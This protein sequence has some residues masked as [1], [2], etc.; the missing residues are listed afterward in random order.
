MASGKGFRGGFNPFRDAHGRFSTPSG[1]GKTPAAHMNN[2]IRTAAGRGGS[3]GGGDGGSSGSNDPVTIAKRGAPGAGETW[4]HDGDPLE[5]RHVVPGTNPLPKMS[6][7]TLDSADTAFL[8]HDG[9]DF[10]T[11]G[12]DHAMNNVPDKAHGL[13]MAISARL[14]ESLRER[15]GEIGP[16][17]AA[18]A[19]KI[20]A[21]NGFTAPA[22]TNTAKAMN[23]LLATRFATE[24]ND[25]VYQ[26]RLQAAALALKSSNSDHWQAAVDLL[27]P[28]AAGVGFDLTLKSIFQDATGKDAYGPDNPN[29]E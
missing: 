14:G 27:D 29:L 12:Y 22:T 25:Q 23:D 4:P 11:Q 15:S 10:M 21:Q 16:D 8:T 26:R 5:G 24:N 3:S 20:L 18:A 17:E 6:K 1:G 7:I 28:D 9:N 2:A 19:S 13:A